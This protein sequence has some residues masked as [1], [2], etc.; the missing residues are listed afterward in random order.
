MTTRDFARF[1]LLYLRRGS[2]DG[3]QVVS[4]DFVEQA[5]A[6]S[7]TELNAG[8]GYLFWLNHRGRIGSPAL[9]W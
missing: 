1:G 3:E 9:A 7:S 4:A 2:W 8:Y 5:T 6:V